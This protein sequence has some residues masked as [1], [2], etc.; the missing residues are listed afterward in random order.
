[1]H[2]CRFPDIEVEMVCHGSLYNLV[3]LLRYSKLV[4]QD[5]CQRRIY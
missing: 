4:K 3:I 2:G 1:M 5:Y